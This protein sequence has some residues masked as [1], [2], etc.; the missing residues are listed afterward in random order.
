M[1]DTHSPPSKRPRHHHHPHHSKPK[2]PPTPEIPSTNPF[3]TSFHYF[4]TELDEHHDRRE[5]LIKA[6]RDV[7]A[8][9]KKIIFS[10]QR[11]RTFAQPLPAQILATITP[12]HTSITT[13]LT[14]IAPDLTPPNAH[15]YHRQI[16]PGIQ[17]LI[18][19]LAFQHYLT[20]GLLLPYTTAR[21]LVPEGIDVHTS[22]YVLGV[23]DFVGEVMRWGITMV[24]LRGGGEGGDEMVGRVLCD[25]REL[26]AEL[27]ALGTSDGGGRFF[28]REWEKKVEVMRTCVQKVE[29]AV[30]GV[31]VR[32]SEMPPG[33]VPDDGDGERLGRD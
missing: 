26:R 14:S 11:T 16:S 1:A 8:L 7:T 18:E 21:T 28:G 15:R 33:W 23:F 10:L 27:E 13:T 3:T 19:A 29:N 30:C 24:A 32:G 20:T 2:P 17:E 25:L 6:S 12:Y 9:S 4:R 5:R 31:V 22:D